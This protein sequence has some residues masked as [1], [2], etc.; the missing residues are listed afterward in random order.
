MDMSFVIRRERELA[1]PGAEVLRRAFSDERVRTALQGSGKR[2]RIYN[3]VTT[4]CIWLG[5]VLSTDHSCRNAL[6]HARS[7]GLVPA[8]TSVHTGAY[9]QARDRLDEA[10]LRSIATGLGK[11]LSDSEKTEDR[12]R[13]R[14]VVIPDGSSITLPDTPANQAAYPQS[15][16]QKPGCGFPLMYLCT[17]ISLASGGMLD[18]ETGSSSDNELSLWR[19]LWRW[20]MQGDIVLGDGKYASYGDIALLRS[21]GVDT[22]ARLRAR[23]TDFGKGT[24]IALNDHIVQWIRP[25]KL[26]VWLKDKTLPE[27]MLVREL[28]FR[29]EIPG[30]RPDLV[31]LATTLLDSIEYPQADIAELFFRRWQVEL[32][33]RDIKTYLGMEALRTKT[34]A[35]ARKELWMFLAAYNVLH[36]L[37]NTAALKAQTAVTR[38]SFQ[39]CRQRLVAAAARNC[40]A[41]KFPSSYRKLIRDIAKDGVPYRPFRVEPRAIKRRKKGYDLINQPRIVLQQK[42]MGVAS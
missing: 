29:V 23:K 19:R 4:F 22:V 2:R 12:W 17:L 31:I 20:L 26:P 42:L 1:V 33:L 39:G 37:M 24:I 8:K 13:G 36:S 5:Q 34:P 14:R 32:R 38:I 27:T 30:F 10:S 11:T 15:S 7:A 35:R 16:Q 18:F 21:K 9:C 3:P 40:S 25:R 28:R 6:A 41:G